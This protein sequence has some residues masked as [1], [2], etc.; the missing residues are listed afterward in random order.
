MNARSAG[1]LLHLTA[2]PN[3]Y[4][5]GDL[6]SSAYRFVDFLHQAAQRFWQMLPIGPT[7]I[8]NS[9]YAGPSAFGGNP[10]L[11]SPDKLY[12]QGLLN[13]YDLEK[14]QAR[15]TNN[16]HYDLVLRHKTACLHQAFH[17]FETH[18]SRS[19]LNDFTA[20][21]TEEAYWLN[22]FALFFALLTQLKTANWTRWPLALRH[23]QK[24]ALQQATQ[25]LTTPIRYHQFV[26]WQFKR[27]WQQ[28]KSY[29]QQQ[30]IELIG[31]LPL[32][33]AHQ[34]VD[35]WAHPELF[36]LNH[37]V[38]TVIAGVPPDYFSAT[39]QFWN[40]PVYCWNVVQQQQYSWWIARFCHILEQ[41]DYLRLDH[42]I[43]FTRIYEIPAGE[44]TAASGHYVPINSRPLFEKLRM[45]L[46][47]LPFIAEDLGTKT[48]EANQLREYFQIP[49]MQVF[50]FDAQA[51]LKHQYPP[52]TV[53]YS[54]TH[55]N[56]T[57]RGW[58]NHLSLEEKQQ[59]LILLQTNEQDFLSTLLQQLYAA[60]AETVIVPMQDLLDLPS[61]ARMNYPGRTHGNWR[62][63]MKK[64]GLQPQ[65]AAQLQ[66]LM[67]LMHRAWRNA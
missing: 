15:L 4:S 44:T 45:I 12:E 34:S 1:I 6:G 46:G 53:L 66:Q 61:R 50:Q 10:L 30:H 59:L 13:R 26:Q 21:I 58:F 39:G 28:L 56:D 16:I 63:R 11:I 14:V 23:R 19:L 51:I 7:G 32:F 42:F 31:D 35:V 5:I 52:Q 20:F 17:H 40:V 57:T 25:T 29:C 54:G 27:Q 37:D 3:R 22:D 24:K 2:L 38:P 65:F 8:A 62:W 43:G 55:D 60:P 33:V 18:S 47:T 36:K 48:P 67:M 41:F 49:G 9:P 64:N